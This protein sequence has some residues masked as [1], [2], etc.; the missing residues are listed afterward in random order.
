MIDSRAGWPTMNDL[1][2][3]T[4]DLGDALA[5]HC[6]LQSFTLERVDGSFDVDTK[7]DLEYA[8]KHFLGDLRPARGKLVEEIRRLKISWCCDSNFNGK[9]LSYRGSFHSSLISMIEAIKRMP[10]NLAYHL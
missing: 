9:D 3:G 10:V 1:P 8:A 6:E 5:K 7:L 4:A 2:W